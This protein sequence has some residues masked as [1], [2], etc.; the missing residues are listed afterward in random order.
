V[1]LD[2]DTNQ[3]IPLKGICADEISGA[4]P[5]ERH[6]NII[7]VCRNYAD[8]DIKVYYQNL[9]CT[10]PLVEECPDWWPQDAVIRAELGSYELERTFVEALLLDPSPLARCDQARISWS[11]VAGGLELVGAGPG[12]FVTG[13]GL[14]NHDLLVSINDRPIVDFDDALTALVTFR[15]GGVDEYRVLIERDGELV[16]STYTVS[17]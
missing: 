16:S 4:Y 10:Q 6:G 7:A 17:P 8:Q 15:F 12:D 5:D 9:S 3:W 2:P 1:T 13:L 11:E 14:R